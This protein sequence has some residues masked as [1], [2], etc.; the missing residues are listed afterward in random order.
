MDQE[1]SSNLRGLSRDDLLVYSDVLTRAWKQILWGQTEANSIDLDAS[2]YE[3]GGD[4]IGL[5]QVASLLEQEG[6]KLR[7]EDLVDHPIMIEQLA[8]LAMYKKKVKE[9]ED[10]E[11]AESAVPAQISEVPRKGLKKMLG[12]SIGLAKRIRQRKGGVDTGGKGNVRM[13]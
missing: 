7:V 3:L 9:G 1:L 5:A 8:L 2:F 11:A 12:K 6:Y 13:E 10:A 4:I